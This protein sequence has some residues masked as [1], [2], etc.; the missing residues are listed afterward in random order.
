MKDAEFLRGERVPMTKEEVRSALGWVGIII[1]SPILGALIYAV[2]GIN[3]IRRSSIGLQR[4][5]LLDRGREPVDEYD[6]TGE[7][8]AN[9]FGQRFASMKLLG[10]KVSRYGMCTGNRITMLEGGDIAYAAM[11]QAITRAKRSIL[12]ETYIF[13]R[14]PI[15]LRFGDALIAAVDD[16]LL[17]APG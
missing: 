7:S 5:T 13:D 1:L 11:M 15:G 12:L 2:A 3:R 4:V 8:V 16:M 6:V 9:R 17:A 14:D 10:D